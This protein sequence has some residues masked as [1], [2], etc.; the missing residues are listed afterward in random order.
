MIAASIIAEAQRLL[1]AGLSYRQVAAKTGISRGSVGEIANGRISAK[2]RRD[3]EWLGV[4]PRGR[5]ARCPTCG[6]MVVMP[7]MA[8][9]V[10]AA[11][12]GRGK[13]VEGREENL[14]PDFDLRPE[15][16][17]RLDRVRRMRI[18]A[19]NAGQPLFSFAL[20]AEDEPI[21]DTQEKAPADRAA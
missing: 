7:C 21:D 20:S 13:R 9:R 4:N 17:K 15:Q 8:C 14:R 12:K 10:R 3:K 11:K 19:G 5:P 16:Q 1:A 18:A 2:R 6:G